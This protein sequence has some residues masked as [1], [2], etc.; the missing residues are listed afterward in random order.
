LKVKLYY[1]LSFEFDYRVLSGR[2]G[3]KDTC[4]SA[5]STIKNDTLPYECQ[6][7]K[8]LTSRGAGK[9]APEKQHQDKL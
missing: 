7:Q 6:P 4:E 9:G 2:L 1:K 3:I 5:I 8:R